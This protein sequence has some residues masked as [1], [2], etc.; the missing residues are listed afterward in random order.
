MCIRIKLVLFAKY[1]YNTQ[2]KEDEMG[3]VCSTNEE[4]RNAYKI[5]IGKAERKSH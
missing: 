5:F 1:N 2:V 4:N 3:R